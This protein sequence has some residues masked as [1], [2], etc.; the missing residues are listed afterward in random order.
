MT[1]QLILHRQTRALLD[2]F[3]KN[4]S[5][6]LI[7]SGPSGI[8]KN[9]VANWIAQ[10]LGLSVVDITVDKDK[11]MIGIDQIQQLYVQTRS[12]SSLCIIVDTAELLTNDAQNAFLKLLEE[13][14]SN[15]YF[16]MTTI[17]PDLL[18]QT[19]RSRSQIIIIHPPATKDIELFV[20]SISTDIK[21]D[22]LKSLIRSSRGLPGSLSGLL[23]DNEQLNLHLDSINEAKEFLSGK[24]QDRLR[25]L[26]KHSF[27]SDWCLELLKMT[28]L[29]IESLLHVKSQDARVIKRLALQS[30]LIEEVSSALA[31]S[32]N[33]KI[34]LT[35]FAL[36]L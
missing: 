18:L 22:N 14:P 1:D 13:P 26:S 2:S 4:P 33:P 19:I 3:L 6:A 35:K 21:S 25:V 16:I 23:S 9:H 10:E 8:G 24:P 17:D 32:G 34:H 20:D 12:A 15:T 27:D 7:L 29:L 31:M 5:Q 36:E 28:S 30:E 11:K